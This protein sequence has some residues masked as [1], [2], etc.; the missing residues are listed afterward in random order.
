MASANLQDFYNLI[1]VYI[2]AVFH[3]RISEDIFRQEGWHVE[4]GDTKGPWTYKGVVYNEMK[5]AYSSPDSVLAEQSQQAV[6][7]D[8]LYSLDSG[9]NPEAIPDLTYEAFRDFHSRYYHPSNARFFFW[10][11]D[12][13]ENP[14]GSWPRPCRATPPARWIPPC[15]CSPAA[16]RP[17]QVEVPYAATDGQKTALFTVNWLLGER[18]DVH[19]ALLMEMLEHILEGLPGSPLRKALISSGLGED[20]TGC[21]L[22]TDLRQMYY[23][24]GLKGVDPRKVQDAEMLIFETLAALAEDGI[25]PPPWRPP[26]TAWNSPTARTIPAASRAGSRP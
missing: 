13:E 3:P 24:T 23:S 1:D 17:R 19:Q 21:G 25:D 5:G 16:T 12:P 6:F 2:D 8:M 26:S 22:E 11:D 10:G 15:P 14:R 4:A 7:P 9:G 20:T 18:G